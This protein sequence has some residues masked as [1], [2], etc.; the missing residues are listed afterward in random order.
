LSL[1]PF[2]DAVAL[3]AVGQYYSP[4]EHF[5]NGPKAHISFGAEKLNRIRVRSSDSL[6]NAESVAY[7]K[8]A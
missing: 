5:V 6:A 3:A 8:R 1:L 2:M 4:R 7:T